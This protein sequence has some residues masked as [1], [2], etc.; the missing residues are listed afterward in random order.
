MNPLIYCF[1]VIVKIRE[2]G[3][4]L[5][6]LKKVKCHQQTFYRLKICHE[7]SHLYIYI[8][9]YIYIRKRSS[10]KTGPCGTPASIFF[11]EELRPF[12]TT[13]CFWFFKQFSKSIIN[14]SST[15]YVFNLKIIPS[16]QTL[17]KALKI[18]RNTPLTSSGDYSR[19]I[20]EFLGL[21]IV[22]AKHKNRLE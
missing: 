18:F 16:C 8:Y 1:Q 3:Q 6:L 11:Q 19:I 9:I 7:V 22:V 14:F 5:S 2:I 21:Q 20:C 4:N 10:P 15:P 17:S 13:L 12:R